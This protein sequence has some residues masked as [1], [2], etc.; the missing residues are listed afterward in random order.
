MCRKQ[1]LSYAI[2]AMFL[3]L[4][5]G[6]A[7]PILVWTF[8]EGTG[9]TVSDKS[10]NGHDGVINGALWEAGG[11]N[12]K[13][14]AL[15]F[16]GGTTVEDAAGGDYLNGLSAT[17][18]AIWIKSN[19]TGSNKGFITGVEPAGQD[20][21]FTMRYDSSGASFGGT[22]ILKMGI[23]SEGG[24]QQIESSD[25]LQTTE[26]QHV[27]M[28]WED[29][30]EIRFYVNGVEDEVSGRNT[31]NNTGATSEITAL[32]I[33]KG[34]KDASSGWNG[35]IDEVRIFDTALNAEEIQA[36][37][38][39]VGGE[40]ASNP[41][42]EGG[43]VDVLRDAELSW[44]SG[45][46]AATHNVYFGESFEDVNSAT[47]PTSANQNANA[48]DPGRLEFGR[49]YYWRVDEV[50]G[51]PDKTVFGGEVWSFEAE[52]YSILIPG[53]ALTVTASSVTNEFSTPEK[54]VD[55]S[56][57]GADKT[58]T[59]SAEA[60]WFTDSVDLD[61]WIQ[62]EFDEVKKLDIM[63]VWNS[64]G[65]AEMAIGWGV[66]DVEIQYSVDGETWDVLADA[67]QFGRAPG[68][69]TYN[70]PDE[71]D[72]GGAAAR[73]VRLDIQSNWGG[74]LMSYS[75]S[76]VQFNMIPAVARTPD[77]VSGAV[78]ARPDA[79]VA[80]R[81]GRDAD[82][83][84]LYI[85]ADQNEVAEGLASSVTTSTNSLD[86]GSLD[87]D[88]GQ[89]Y[90]WRVD[91][92][93][94]AEAVPVWAGPVWQLSLVEAVTV[95]DFESYSNVSPDRPFQSWLD[96]FGYSAD[97]FFPVEY[98][99]NGT[100]AGIGH[101]IWSLSSPH[102]D[103]DIMETSN[104]VAGSSQSMPFYYSNSGGVASETQHTFAVPQDWTVGGAQTLSIAFN[105]QAGN[106]G[107]LYAK[108]NNT[109]VTYQLDAGNLAIGAWQVWNID[110]TQVAGNL[111]SVSSMSIGVDG[112]S[113]SGMILFDDMKLYAQPGELITPVAPDSAG[114]LAQYS[115]NGNA[116]D[117]SGNG[118]HGTM[119]GSQVVSPGALNQGSAVQ[120]AP[121]GF[122]DLGNPG[123]LDLGTGDWTVSAWFKT[124]M[125]GTGDANKGTIV[126]K[127]G[128]SGGG[129]RY[130]L[131]MSE[132]SE[133]VISLV[134]DD[135]STKY[136]VNAVSVTNDDLWHF[137]AGQKEGT[138]IRIY[139]D[140]QLEGT[141]TADPGYDLSGTSQHN[142]YIGAITNNGSGSRY[143]LLD[144]AV[145]EVAIY[146]RAL[147][148][149]EL[150]WMAGRTTP[151]EKPF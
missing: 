74:I 104:T 42:P 80:W 49:T 35:L 21:V 16:E 82:T 100:G 73:F 15:S 106:T 109:K 75:L 22:D 116:D 30:G 38:L 71:I 61:P 14:F 44:S 62:Y 36:V 84:T 147:S 149:E 112:A 18:V 140:G 6:G 20:R 101:D 59:T 115:F 150:L 127:G 37:M 120:I 41:V 29:G 77:P 52:P 105:G 66:K 124:G 119:T 76:E 133:G 88:L 111:S 17:T 63:T 19:E 1:I 53:S 48:F 39:G 126:G 136:V 31:P 110:L 99:G 3:C 13:G 23:Q 132:S 51:T 139:I 55:G 56:G 54:T 60:M 90:Y 145:D 43:A 7:D 138:E 114:L 125:T 96:G 47:V 121:G 128:D 97:E 72:F 89:T 93:N 64:N 92:V 151:I 69:P 46:F 50:N 70:Q 141:A 32:I 8:D 113:A 78:D 58:H 117:S 12:G 68:S 25:N 11:F 137:V 65:A 33:G 131:I 148:A 107:T 10:G 123:S 122:V 4:S 142:A 87:L 67:T 143:K 118:L 34:G 5:T 130:A 26:W 40:S 28:T 57:L 95:D 129:H 27:A 86:L 79:V 134:T 83:H 81:A 24:D 98:A 94:E 9:G 45:E 91:E 144:G 135:N 85:S 2:L 108:I 102:Y 146:S 103:G